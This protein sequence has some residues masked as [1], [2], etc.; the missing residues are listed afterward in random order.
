[1]DW[2]EHC[3]ELPQYANTFREH[4]ITGRQLP[5]IAINYGQILQSMLL[6]TDSQHKQ[7]IQLRAMDVVLFGPPVQPSQWKDTIVIISIILC[8]CGIIYALRQRK[9]SKAHIDKFIADL[10]LKEE[11]VKR[12]KSKFEELESLGEEEAIDGPN[13]IIM[14]SS[15]QEGVTQEDSPPIMISPSNVSSSDEESTY[16]RWAAPSSC[17]HSYQINSK[18]C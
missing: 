7:K 6:I 5:Y 15:N 2:L 3:V 12:L 13:P 11:E 14:N 16:C 10:K 17:T 9:I 1:M 4:Q 18:W 8:T